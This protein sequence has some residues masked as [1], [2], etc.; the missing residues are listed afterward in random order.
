MTP[1]RAQRFVDDQS[2]AG[3]SQRQRRSRMASG[4]HR[5]SSI[6]RTVVTQSAISALFG[7]NV[8]TLN[9]GFFD[10]F[11]ALDVVFMNIILGL[12]VWIDPRPFQ[13]H[14]RYLSMIGKHLDHA[15][16]QFDWDAP[17][18]QWKSCFG[19]R[20]CRDMVKWLRDAGLWPKE[21]GSPICPGRN[22]AKAEIFTMVTLVVDRFDIQ[23]G[24]WTRPNGAPLDSPA[25]NDSRYSAS[26]VVPPN[27]DMTIR[28]KRKY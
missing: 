8:L 21:G 16:E 22:F 12:P 24:K 15:L 6:C 10:A 3:L 17:E 20:I 7:P 4:A 28:W 11:W 9:A 2:G 27:R 13:A 26:G 5:A 25:E 1:A 18:R 14:N 23:F 19:A